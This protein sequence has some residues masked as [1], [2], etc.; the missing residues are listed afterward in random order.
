MEFLDFLIVYLRLC[1]SL[2]FPEVLIPNKDST[3]GIN[4]SNPK[5]TYLWPLYKKYFKPQAKAW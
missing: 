3:P 1:E 5:L 2:S 4:S